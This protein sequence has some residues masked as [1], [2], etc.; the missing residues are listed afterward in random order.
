MT[1]CPHTA[2]EEASE[3]QYSEI[4]PSLNTQSPYYENGWPHTE[5]E[6]ATEFQWTMKNFLLNIPFSDFTSDSKEVVKTQQSKYWCDKNHAE[7]NHRQMKAYFVHYEEVQKSCNEWQDKN[8]DKIKTVKQRSYWKKIAENQKEYLV[9]CRQ[10]HYNNSEKAAAQKNQFYWAN[11]NS[12]LDKE[13]DWYNLKS[14][15]K[16][17]CKT[18]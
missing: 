17:W 18:A 5:S 13:W 9:K 2:S 6:K 3:Y 14:E 11:R 7:I 4:D 8:K 10:W 12:I 1:D 15:Y 16:E